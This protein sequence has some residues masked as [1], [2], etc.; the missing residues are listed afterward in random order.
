MHYISC[1][2]N[3]IDNHI[4]DNYRYPFTPKRAT[5]APTLTRC[6]LSQVGKIHISEICARHLEKFNF[7]TTFRGKLQI[8]VS[9]RDASWLKWL[10][11]HVQR[12]VADML[13]LDCKV[14]LGKLEM[15]CYLMSWMSFVAWL[16]DGSLFCWGFVNEGIIFS[17]VCAC[18]RARVCMC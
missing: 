13:C 10:V 5:T 11:S 3:K 14:E 18:V 2:N 8:K 15:C 12:A 7:V 6:L 16:K 1:N 17:C 9:C 4:N